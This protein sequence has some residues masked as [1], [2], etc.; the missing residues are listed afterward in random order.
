MLVDPDI[1]RAFAGSVDAASA[2]IRSADVGNKASAAG[3]GLPG[4][5]TQWA[6]RLVGAHITAEANKIAGSVTSMGAAVRGAGDRYEVADGDLA[7]AFD[8][9]F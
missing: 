4:S 5:T 1:L 2:A 6:C 7:A 9:L 3:D 8:K